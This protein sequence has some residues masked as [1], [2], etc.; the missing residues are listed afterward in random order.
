MVQLRK[1]L[2]QEVALVLRSGQV[3]VPLGKWLAEDLVLAADTLSG[4]THRQAAV[5][6]GIP[7]T[8]FRRQLQAA[9]H[10]RAA[11]LSV[12]SATWPAVTSTLEGLIRSRPAGRDTC[13]WAEGALLAE[14]EAAAPGDSRLAAALV[15]VTETTL[16]R[17]RAQVHQS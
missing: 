11:R 10:R 12:R 6:L 3:A 8:T 15:G 9:L 5:L 4:G 16:L 1:A 14:I 7:E 2:S 17:R 13:E